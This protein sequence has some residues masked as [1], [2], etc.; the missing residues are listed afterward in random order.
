[1]AGGVREIARDDELLVEGEVAG[2]VTPPG[3]VAA[4][5]AWGGGG[6]AAQHEYDVPVLAVVNPGANGGRRW[7]PAQRCSRRKGWL[8]GR[9]FQ[10]PSWWLWQLV[11]EHHSVATLCAQRRRLES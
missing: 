4:I 8:D 2:V 7:Q 10:D 5:S 3:D 11:V 1:V 9:H 6:V